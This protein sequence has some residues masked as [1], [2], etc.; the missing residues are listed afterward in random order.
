MAMLVFPMNLWLWEEYVCVL[1]V[2]S[3]SEENLGALGSGVTG[4]CELAVMG[5]VN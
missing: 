5:A 2:T 1:Q 3:S 4:A